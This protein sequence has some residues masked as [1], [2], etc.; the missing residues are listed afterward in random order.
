[1][2]ISSI[3][4]CGPGW[5][6]RAQVGA[7]CFGR[8]REPRPLVAGF[9]DAVDI[10]AAMVAVCMFFYQSLGQLK[11]CLPEGQDENLL[12][13]VTQVY[14]GVNEPQTAEYVS[15]RLG[16]TNPILRKRRHQ[17]RNVAAIQREGVRKLQHFVE[18]EPELATAWAQA[19]KARRSPGGFHLGRRSPSRRAFRRSARD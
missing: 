1:M 3:A 18:L 2:W 9:D 14:F 17:P 10:I 8:G 13:N 4:S 6:S 5:A 11:K 16:E 15:N 7:F 19:A 12:S